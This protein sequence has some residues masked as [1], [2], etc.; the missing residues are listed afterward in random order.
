M[1]RGEEVP[2]VWRADVGGVRKGYP[3]G[4]EVVYRRF[5]STCGGFREKVFQ[6]SKR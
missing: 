3:A 5:T 6:D 1:A 2:A 4:T